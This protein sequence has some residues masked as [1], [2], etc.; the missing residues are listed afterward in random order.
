[1]DTIEAYGFDQQLDIYQRYAG[2][3]HTWT[4][5]E[6]SNGYAAA[7]HTWGQSYHGGENNYWQNP[8]LNIPSSSQSYIMQESVRGLWFTN[9]HTY[10]T[11][12]TEEY[13]IY[14]CDN[15]EFWRHTTT[16]R[17]AQDYIYFLIDYAVGGAWPHDLSRY[18]GV[19]DMYVD[20]VRV[21]GKPENVMPK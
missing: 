1:L 6:R 9:F 14:Y 15:V 2:D 16:P 20:W 21:Y 12:I 19:S 3:G 4:P 11:L 13:T 5:D 8:A 7:L 10:G 17:S 18:N